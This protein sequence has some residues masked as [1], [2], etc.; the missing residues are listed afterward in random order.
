MLI[1]CYKDEMYPVYS[2]PIFD[3]HLDWGD[4]KIELTDEEFSR[5]R[6][7]EQEF[8]DCQ[9]LLKLKYMIAKSES[10]N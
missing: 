8:S 3:D 1:G 7:A 6:K 9:D 4:Y 2:L 10:R 5:I